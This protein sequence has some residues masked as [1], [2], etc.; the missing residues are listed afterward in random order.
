MLKVWLYL[1]K[2]IRAVFA[3]HQCEIDDFVRDKL[4]LNE[5]D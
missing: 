3:V 2:A 4:V 1:E 5:Q